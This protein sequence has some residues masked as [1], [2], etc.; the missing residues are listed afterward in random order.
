[1][2]VCAYFLVLCLVHL[3]ICTYIL[4]GAAQALSPPFSIL[5]IFSAV[6]V[7]LIV[8]IT[9]VALPFPTDGETM[10]TTNLMD[11]D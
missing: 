5:V 2:C 6:L 7:W 3:F 10:D 4:T 1:V 11:E 9:R 8:A